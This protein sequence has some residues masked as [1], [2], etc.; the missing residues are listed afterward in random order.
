MGPR[1][2]AASG[3]VRRRLRRWR[4]CS[5]RRGKESI[6][7][8]EEVELSC[9]QQWHCGSSQATLGANSKLETRQ[10]GGGP[11]TREKDEAAHAR[12]TACSGGDVSGDGLAGEDRWV[13][14]SAAPCSGSASQSKRGGAR[15][16]VSAR[17]GGAR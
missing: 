3:S 15:A 10:V 6:A 1:A 14:C 4:L 11:F 9:T 7:D 8:D 12:R 16:A 17:P 13:C 5:A 2:A